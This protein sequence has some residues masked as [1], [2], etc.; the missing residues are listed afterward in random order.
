[1][2][3]LRRTAYLEK[4]GIDSYISRRQL[5]GAAPTRRLALRRADEPA[6]MPVAAL[7]AVD[8]TAPAAARLPQLDLSQPTRRSAQPASAPPRP[9][10]NR[11]A[12]I[13][14]SLSAIVAGPFMWLESLG[15]MPLAAEQVSLIRSMAHAVA[16]AQGGGSAVEQTPLV[17][18]FDWPLHQN[19]QFDQS[20]EAAQV[21]LAAFLQ[22]R[23]Q[24][25]VC[26][27]LVLL[28]DD[29]ARWVDPAGLQLTV[30]QTLATTHML[31]DPS[32]KA[33]VWRDL[34][35]LRAAG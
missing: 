31:R 30:V 3:D 27:G 17:E 19:K 13:R 34:A 18:R 16:L 12:V 28:G 21:G 33:Q 7:P 6:S 22:R 35:P 20:A 15:D 2:H 10:Q 32:C 24:Q 5:P 14:F 8:A 4:L 23:L 25:R 9:V 11:D 26:S 29:A 1:M